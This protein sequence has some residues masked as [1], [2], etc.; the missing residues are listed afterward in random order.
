L[1]SFNNYSPAKKQLR[2]SLII[3]LIAACA[4]QVFLEKACA[5]NDN[6]DNSSKSSY[7]HG[8]N[9][10]IK[11]DKQQPNLVAAGPVDR[12]P[13]VA[14][15]SLVPKIPVPK[16][17]GVIPS[18]AP[19]GESTNSTAPTQPTLPE[20]EENVPDTSKSP[21]I[22]IIDALNQALIYNPRAAAIRSQFGI[23]EAGYAAATQM[24][25]PIF[26]FDRGLM[27][28]Q[29]NRIGPSLTVEPPWKLMF[30]FI[31]QKRTLDQARF[32]LMTQLWQ[33][34]SD[35]R[36][37]YTEVVVAQETLKTL[38]ELYD[39]S[40]K[41]EIA[42]SKRFQAG[43]VPELDV[44]RARLATSQ[45][46]ADRIVGVQRVLK[47]RQSLNVIL[48][49]GVDEPVNVPELPDYTQGY[50]S[51]SRFFTDSGLLPDFSKA[52]LPLS[53]F[54]S[55]AEANRLEMKSLYQQVRVNAANLQ[56]SYWNILPNPNI[57][58]GK[59]TQGNVPTGPK[60]TAIFFTLTAVPPVTNTNQGNIAL[61][62]ATSTQLRFQLLSQKNQILSDVTTAYQNLIA[63]RDKLR[64]Y[65]QHILSD[66]YQVA[67]LARRSYE[68]GQSDITA[69][70]A[71][72]QANVQTRSAYLD[73]LSTYQ[74]SFVA[75]EQACGIPLQ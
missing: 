30:R 33:L 71:A 23:T 19:V 7:S 64:T 51:S 35:I 75:L 39:L 38:N 3:A 32:D 31:V 62:K 11:Y 45:T 47:A 67:R 44:M 29:V 36:R 15:P 70:L 40:Y 1:S 74:Q 50:V 42:V 14:P 21:P 65:Q 10:K 53:M 22:G 6:D 60:V 55:M 20:L 2:H 52:M 59:S 73:A 27:A 48:G 28:E 58:A 37:A 69:T 49:R 8:T 54:L 5:K 17:P 43:A 13:A 25:N 66:S 9:L 61:Y 72:Q 24:P 16:A 57:I 18:I 4:I 34:R 56:Q 26:F 68:V 46:A 63:A 12:A 41:L